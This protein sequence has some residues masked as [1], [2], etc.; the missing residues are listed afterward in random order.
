MHFIVL[1]LV[2]CAAASAAMSQPL[3]FKKGPSGIVTTTPATTIVSVAT[4]RLTRPDVDDIVI[5][6]GAAAIL[7][8]QRDGTLV[9]ITEATFKP[10]P[11][12]MDS[13]GLVLGDFNGDGR[14][15][16]FFAGAGEFLVP[17]GEMNRL[18]LSQPDG[19]YR[20]RSAIF[21]PAVTD[22]SATAAVGDVNGDGYLD[23]YVGNLGFDSNQVG[24]YFLLGNGVG[25]F[26]PTSSNLPEN[27]KNAVL[28]Q[29]R[30]PAA[31]LVDVDNDGHLDLI[32]GSNGA[33]S[34]VIL[35][36]DG[37][38]DFTKR[39]PIALPPGLFET[40]TRYTRYASIVAID[41]NGDGFP[42]LVVSQTQVDYIGHGIQALINDGHGGFTDQT[43]AYIVNAVD[44]AHNWIP[45]LAVADLNGDGIPDIYVEGPV[46][47]RD[48]SH[49]PTDPP[50]L[51]WV[52]D[53]LGH[54][55]PMIPLD[56]DPTWDP[57]P[58]INYLF[59]DIDGDGLPDLVQLTSYGDDDPHFGEIPYQVY[60]NV[61]PKPGVWWSK[62]E[63]G[64]GLGLDYQ[65]GTLIVEVYSYLAGGASQWYLA[66]GAIT[67][68]VFTATLDK[69]AGGQCISCVYTAP[70]LSGNDG[71]ITITFTSSTTATADLPGGRHIQIERFFRS[72]SVAG[73]FI[74][75]PG[76]WWNKDESGSGLG[77]DYENG[78]LIAEV[79][80]YLAGG[81]S[82]WY[83]A[84]GPV[85][86]K[87]FTATLD[88]YA[89]G[90]CI[91]C[92]YT[93]PALSGNDGTITIT[94]TSST[95]A[96][97]DLP[98]GRHIQIERFF[99]PSPSQ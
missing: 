61:T 99:R 33:S 67:N 73:P 79:Y 47:H 50:I 53:G 71:T 14:L 87:V 58:P 22:Y 45:N 24:P 66:A 1:A 52:S 10:T 89:G 19:T 41:L 35:L 40:E 57:D 92:V 3:V 18:L 98:G 30:Y 96:T 85:T 42:D 23:I 65:N 86:N 59:T 16:I 44:P 90:Q 28:P 11:P 60:F 97:A 82:Q 39:A 13:A 26:T 94:F 56:V 62:T 51:A 20:D 64:S 43:S 32:L 77:L 81:A 83:L 21:L 74:P 72:A 68:N 12:G 34:P 6:G 36:N 31:A 4:A 78:T 76:V 9:N 75:R 46:F 93:A 88:K 70:A 49:P 80:S 15:D 29:T 69:Y 48:H 54:W 91:S 37:R 8:P 95:T 17:Q 38:G 27:V 84:A 5:G 63:S 55:L 7:A 25:S 2:L